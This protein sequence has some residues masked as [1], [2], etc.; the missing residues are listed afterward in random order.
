MDAVFTVKAASSVVGVIVAESAV[1]APPVNSAP[2]DAEDLSDFVGSDK[3][4]DGFR[5]SGGEVEQAINL[6]NGFVES[7]FEEFGAGATVVESLVSG[8]FDVE[9]A[10][11]GQHVGVENVADIEPAVGNDLFF[12]PFDVVGD[13]D[14][15]SIVIDV[16]DVDAFGGITHKKNLL[17]KMLDSTAKGG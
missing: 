7:D 8:L 5:M 9:S 1:L 6:R 4:R 16:E 3:V 2:V 13:T 14:F 15:D 12:T 10:F 17:Q 11:G